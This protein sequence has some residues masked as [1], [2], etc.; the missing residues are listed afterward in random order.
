MTSGIRRRSME[1]ACSFLLEQAERDFEETRHTMVFPHVAGFTGESE[2]QSSET[3]SRSVLARV[4]SDIGSSEGIKHPL[5]C[6]LPDIIER[7][8]E[9]VAAARLPDR[10]GGWSYF[11]DLPELPPDVDSLAAAALLF[12]RASPQ[13]VH[14]CARPIE[15]VINTLRENGGIRTWIF[16]PNDPHPARQSMERG[17]ELYWGDTVDVEVC[18]HFYLAL[19]AVD[20][21]RYEGLARRGATFILSTQNEN[22]TW[23]ATW[24]WGLAYPTGLCLELLQS[25]GERDE[26]T[27]KAVDF[28]KNS[29]NSDGGWGWSGRASLP[30]E[31]ALAATLLSRSD[32]DSPEEVSRGAIGFLLA[33][34]LS[35]GSWEGSPWIKMEV[36]RAHGTA[37]HTLSYRSTTLTTAMCLRALCDLGGSAI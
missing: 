28:F 6:S 2:Q 34:Q 27:R 36:G 21:R 8:A 18:A 31:T 13:H 12:T 35:D 30:L 17:V 24:Y 16:S 10:E 4:L 11:P 14:L 32:V 37:T 33:N 9:R 7:E 25:L 19:L 22:G 1:A 23:D 20:R 5:F 29:Q 15:L 3:F 26:S